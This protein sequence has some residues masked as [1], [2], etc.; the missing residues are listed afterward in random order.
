MILS[1]NIC[2]ITVYIDETYTAGSADNNKH[3]DIVYNPDKCRRCDFYKTT[4]IH[5]DLFGN[6]LNIALV[7]DYY[8]SDEDCAVLNN[9]I[10]TVL[11]NDCLTQI[12]VKDGTVINRIYLQGCIGTNF[13][14]YRSPNG[15][16]IY[17]EIDIIGLDRNF[18]ELWTFSG[19]D[20]WVSVSGK[21]PFEI[22]S[23]R[24]RLYDFLDNYYEIDFDG[25]VITE[26]PA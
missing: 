19:Q 26:I 16:I 25:K 13:A 12:N 5:I 1:N 3:Y 15:Y 18:K 4:G 17:G 8:S 24:I 6:E 2:R 11:Q 14:L 23:D 22:C 10:L 21:N 20:I 9:E 7:G